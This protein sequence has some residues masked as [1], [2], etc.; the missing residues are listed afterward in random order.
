MDVSIVTAML[1]DVEQGT[2][3]VTVLVTPVS[4]RVVVLVVMLRLCDAPVPVGLGGSGLGG[5]VGIG[6]GEPLSGYTVPLKLQAA[7][8]AVVDDW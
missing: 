1:V 7:S 3:V 2:V 4:I 8:P 5:P 6:N